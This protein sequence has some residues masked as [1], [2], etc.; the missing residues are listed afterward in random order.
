MTSKKLAHDDGRKS[1]GDTFKVRCKH[2]YKVVIFFRGSF[3]AI[4]VDEWQ[5][6]LIAI[7][8]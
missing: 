4:F 6:A 1:G 8:N 3:L 2:L 7:S 5:R